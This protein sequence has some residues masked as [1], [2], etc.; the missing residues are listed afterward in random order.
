M[1]IVF[2]P[3]RLDSDTRQLLRNERPIHLSPKA[4]DVLQLLLERR[5]A[6]VTKAQVLEHVWPGTFVEDANL[7]VVVADIRRALDDDPRA[8]AFI[9][10]VHGRGYAFSGSAGELTPLMRSSSAPPPAP[11]CWLTWGEHARPL[12]S[13]ENVI[14]RDPD[15]E[16]WI[17]ARG[18]SRRHAKITTRP[19]TITIEDLSSTNGTFVGKKKLTAPHEIADGDEIALGPETLTLRVWSEGP[20]AT[21]RVK[22]RGSR[23]KGE[24]KREKGQVR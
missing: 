15:C 16:V 3:F 24:R 19:G 8:P 18:V 12:V 5:P 1:N 23:D 20:A 21:E 14:G 9:R 10:T 22:G 4:F 13:G 7:T 17:D 2:G 6:L 11:R